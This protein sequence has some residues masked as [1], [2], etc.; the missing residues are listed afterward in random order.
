MKVSRRKDQIKP[1]ALLIW[2]ALAGCAPVV[3]QA[4]F[5]YRSDTVEPGDLLGA[6]DGRVVDALSGKPLAGAIVQA[7]WAFEVGR[8]LVGPAGGASQTVATDADG[9]YVIERLETAPVRTRVANVVVVVYQRGYVAYRSDRVFDGTRARTD[10]CQHNNVAKLERWTPSLSHVKH[11]R[12]V[13]GTGAIKRA[14][15]SELVEASLELTSGPVKQT[16]AAAEDTRPL[17]ASI[18]LSVDELKAVTGYQGTFT[19]D[20]LGDIPTSTSYDS[21]HF[22]AAEKAETYDAALRVW[23]LSPAAAQARYDKLLKDVPHAQAKDEMGDQSLRGY[24]GRILAIVAIDTTR[25][26]VI[27]LTCGLDQCRDADQAALLLKR[28][29]TR[30]ERLGQ[31]APKP[32]E[33]A[34]PEEPRPEGSGKPA[35]TAPGQPAPS[36]E[37][38]TEQKPAEENPFQLRPPELKQR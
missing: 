28:I 30:T 12:F 6:F 8:G 18:L 17:D 15:G 37:K 9:H 38:P 13:G 11:V 31:S 7:D 21:R 4:P 3:A 14:L 24:D 2:M 33:E 25:G 29:M 34:P 16:A 36:E 26:V 22:R 23:K 19:V 5:S 32:V 1:T 27:E 10:F 35:E 20:K